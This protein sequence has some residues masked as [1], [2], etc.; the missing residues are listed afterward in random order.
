MSSFNNTTTRVRSNFWY[1]LPI[2]GGIVGGIISW[3]AIRYDD[4]RKAKNCL[5][6]GIILTAIPIILTII[7]ILI[8][9]TIESSPIQLVDPYNPPLTWIT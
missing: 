1:I 7:P 5:L 9:G 3:F 6:L 4:P 2:F 8:F